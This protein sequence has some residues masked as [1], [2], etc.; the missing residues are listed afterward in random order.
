MRTLLRNQR[1]RVGVDVLVVA[2]EGKEKPP[3]DTTKTVIIGTQQDRFFARDV[4]N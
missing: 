1:V 4:V 2:Q 3:T